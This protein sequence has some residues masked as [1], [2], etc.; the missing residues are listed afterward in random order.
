M[1]EHDVKWGYIRELP[2]FIIIARHHDGFCMFD[3]PNA[4]YL[5]T[6]T[7]FGRDICLELSQACKRSGRQSGFYSWIFFYVIEK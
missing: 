2:S 6:K 7:P 5:I 3:A 4:D 1:S